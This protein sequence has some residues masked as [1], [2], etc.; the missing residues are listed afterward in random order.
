MEKA[1][2]IIGKKVTKAERMEKERER[3]R[4]RGVQVRSTRRA[5]LGSI[6]V[7]LSFYKKLP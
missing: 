4:E 5:I 7:C 3:D 1:V 2:G 6:L